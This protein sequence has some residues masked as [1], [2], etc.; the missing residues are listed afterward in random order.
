MFKRA[1]EWV[2]FFLAL[3]IVL[4][5]LDWSLSGFLV[6]GVLCFFLLPNRE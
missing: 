6:F 4:P 2:F 3:V 1:L 5:R